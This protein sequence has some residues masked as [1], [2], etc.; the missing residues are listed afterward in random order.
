MYKL[1]QPI[2]TPHFY[3]PEGTIGVISGDN[4]KFGECS[5]NE[6]FVKDSPD[7]FELMPT[8]TD[9]DMIAFGMRVFR[10]TRY[11]NRK[12]GDENYVR[13]LFSSYVNS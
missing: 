13:S 6:K 12:E 4:I 1:L 5:F 9:E 2:S 3:V 10:A 8:W 11:I 7:W